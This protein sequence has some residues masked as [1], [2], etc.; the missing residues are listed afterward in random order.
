MGGCHKDKK[1]I[2]FK[3]IYIFFKNKKIKLRR[4]CLRS[5]GGGLVT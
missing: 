1:E 2:E 5:L 3:Y 4:G